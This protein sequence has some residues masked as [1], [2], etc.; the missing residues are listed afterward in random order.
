MEVEMEV[1][2]RCKS[3]RGEEVREN[4]SETV[5]SPL[6]TGLNTQTTGQRTFSNAIVRTN[7]CLPCGVLEGQLEPLSPK[8]SSPRVLQRPTDF[9]RLP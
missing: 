1:L 5:P 8:W 7:R 9:A 2:R 6:V 3:E 4:G